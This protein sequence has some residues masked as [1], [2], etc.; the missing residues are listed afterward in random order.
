MMN[1]VASMLIMMGPVSTRV[2]MMAIMVMMV[3]IMIM[4]FSWARDD[5]RP[6]FQ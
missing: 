2:I 1:M 5:K 6:I 4:L 3:M